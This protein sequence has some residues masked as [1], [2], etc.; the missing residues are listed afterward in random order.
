MK[1]PKFIGLASLGALTWFIIRQYAKSKE[2]NFKLINVGIN[3]DKLTNLLLAYLPLRVKAYI[4]NP[5][6]FEIDLKALKLDIYL[7][8][9]FIGNIIKTFPSATRIKA[10]DKSKITLDAEIDL[11]RLGK[12]IRFFMDYF[13]GLKKGKIYVKGYL[14][15]NLG[16]YQINENISL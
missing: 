5:T 8:D 3:K 12:T 4:I 13:Q 1:L 10:K 7:N 14:I 16:S 9:E 15:S 11:T 6:D 2:V